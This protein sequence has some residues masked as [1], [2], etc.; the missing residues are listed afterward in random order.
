MTDAICTRE[1]EDIDREE[2]IAGV[3]KHMLSLSRINTAKACWRLLKYGAEVVHHPQSL[4]TKPKQIEWRIRQID[5]RIER[6][7]KP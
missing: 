1:S 6:I 5:G 7:I 2:R 3:T 4:I